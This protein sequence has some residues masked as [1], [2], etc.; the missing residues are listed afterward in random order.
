MQTGRTLKHY[1][2]TGCYFA[3]IKYNKI[4]YLIQLLTLAKLINAFV[5]TCKF[6]GDYS[7]KQ[8]LELGNFP[9]EEPSCW[10][11]VNA[12]WSNAMKYTILYKY[13]SQ[14]TLQTE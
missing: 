13:I 10:S 6:M 12:A 5:S 2:Y 3:K 7:R 9:R 8:N 1:T 14:D 4:R 11:C